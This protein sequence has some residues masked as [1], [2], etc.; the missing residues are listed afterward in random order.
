MSESI[1]LSVTYEN[2]D[3][4]EITNKPGDPSFQFRM[5]GSTAIQEEGIEW[6]HTGK[7]VTEGELE[8]MNAQKRSI[9][10]AVRNLPF[11]QAIETA[12][13]HAEDATDATDSEETEA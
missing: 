13:E 6:V 4:T 7:N 2:G 5:E 1:R 3:P 11:V 9:L 10:I 8:Q 12:D